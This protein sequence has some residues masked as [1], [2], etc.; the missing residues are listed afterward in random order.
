MTTGYESALFYHGF[1]GSLGRWVIERWNL[2]VIQIAQRPNDL[3][4]MSNTEVRPCA[5]LAEALV[6]SDRADRRYDAQAETDPDIRTE[7]GVLNEVVE[8]Y[9]A[10]R[11]APG[12]ADVAKKDAGKAVGQWEAVFQRREKHVVAPEPV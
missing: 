6:D 2:I 4:N 3:E 5:L 11:A 9:P 7:T 8:P 12:V 10:I 1:V